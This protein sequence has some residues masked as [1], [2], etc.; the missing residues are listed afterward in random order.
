ML[1]FA[2]SEAKCCQARAAGASEREINMALD[3]AELTAVIQRAKG[4]FIRDALDEAC[5]AGNCTHA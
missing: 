2:V 4:E 3:E 1:L 5:P